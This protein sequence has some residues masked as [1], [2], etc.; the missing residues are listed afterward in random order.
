MGGDKV[1]LKLQ[2]IFLTRDKSVSLYLNGVQIVSKGERSGSSG[3]FAPVD[4]GFV[5]SVKPEIETT[6]EED[7][8]F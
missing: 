3:G 6:E 5:A 1:K 7:L 4:G 8:P 2:P